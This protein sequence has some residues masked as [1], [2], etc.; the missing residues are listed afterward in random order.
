MRILRASGAELER[1]HA[2]GA[3]RQLFQPVLSDESR[4]AGLLGGEAAPGAWLIDPHDDDRHAVAARA[5]AGPARL[6]A[7]HALIPPPAPHGP[8]LVA[9]DHPPRP[10]ETAPP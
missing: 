6:N 10:H 1:E 8:P 5:Q 7:I 2:F 4:R 3:I 9:V